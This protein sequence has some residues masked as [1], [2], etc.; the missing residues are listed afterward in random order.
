MMGISIVLDQEQCQMKAKS[1]NVETQQP[2]QLLKAFQHPL[3]IVKRSINIKK[4]FGLCLL[5]ICVTNVSAFQSKEPEVQPKPQSYSVD[6]S[7]F[8]VPSEEYNIAYGLAPTDKDQKISVL[9][10]FHGEFRILGSK[11][12]TDDVQAK[13]SPIDYAVTRGIFTRPDIASQ[14]SIKQYDRYLNW[15]MARPPLPPQIATQL[16]SNMHIIPANPQVAEEIKKVQRGDL[17]QLSGDLVQI[18]DKDLVW[19]SA[20]DWTGVG[21]G[22]CKLIR[23]D[24]IQWIEK[25]NI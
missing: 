12:Y 23:V 3:N 6:T 21:D 7:D 9:E 10:A 4:A 8:Y 20:L 14:I 2:R 11:E 15:Q 18:N 1:E 24:S 16:V 25:Q 13:F 19:K 5:S 17:V 22:A